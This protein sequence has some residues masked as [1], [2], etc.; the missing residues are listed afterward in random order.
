MEMFSKDLKNQVM[1]IINYEKKEMIPLRDDEHKSYEKRKECHICKKEFYANKN[2]ENEFKKFKI[3]QED[4]DFFFFLGF[5]FTN[6][7]ESQDCRGRGGHFFNSSL[8]LPPASQ[9]LRY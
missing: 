8:P 4:K 7:Q 9:T 5:S 3:Y 1:E 6:I 2:D